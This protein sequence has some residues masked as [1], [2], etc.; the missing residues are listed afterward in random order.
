MTMTEES[1]AGIEEGIRPFIEDSSQIS[2]AFEI[3]ICYYQ[4][5]CN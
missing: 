5:L 1:L 4:L 2:E 3:K